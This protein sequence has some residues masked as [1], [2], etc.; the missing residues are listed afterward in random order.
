LDSMDSMKQ[1]KSHVDIFWK[2]MNM[3]YPLVN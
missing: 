1:N 2:V 3:T